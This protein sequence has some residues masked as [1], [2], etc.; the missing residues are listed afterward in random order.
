M[1]FHVSKTFIFTFCAPVIFLL[2]WEY[3]T[4]DFCNFKSGFDCKPKK[5]QRLELLLCVFWLFDQLCNAVYFYTV[6]DKTIWPARTAGLRKMPYRAAHEY[7]AYLRLIYDKQK[8]TTHI[9]KSR[10]QSVKYHHH[11]LR[12]IGPRYLQGSVSTLIVSI[13]SSS[14]SESHHCNTATLHAINVRLQRMFLQLFPF[15][16]HDRVQ[17]I[18]RLK[19]AAIGIN[20]YSQHCTKILNKVHNQWP[21][22]LL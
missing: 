13:L 10:E 21:T 15:I 1:L 19:L 18:H 9:Q 12:N 11:P 22:W 3:C 8:G 7:K 2:Q 16:Y 4:E 14:N 5:G 6:R 17:V 20:K